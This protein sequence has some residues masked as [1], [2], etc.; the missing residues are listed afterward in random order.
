MSR[1]KPVFIGVAAC[2]ALLSAYFIL[3]SALNSKEHAVSEFI[4]LWPWMVSLS[5]GFG[6][7]VG[8]F[9]RIREVVKTGVGGA[10]SVAAS[11]SVSSVSM[12]ACCVHHLVD[13]LPFIGLSAFSLFLV[14]YQ[15]VFLSV[16]LVSSLL[17]IA[18]MLRTLGKVKSCRVVK[19]A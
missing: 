10:A 18:V 3:V 17:G 2:A 15:V 8:L 12:A 1:I 16:G 6:V 5:V 9:F 4:R 11:G 19:D 14:R 7:Q 13:V